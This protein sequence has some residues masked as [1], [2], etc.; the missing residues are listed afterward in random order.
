MPTTWIVLSVLAALWCGAAAAGVFGYVRF[1]RMGPTFRAK[2]RFPD[3]QRWDGGHGWPR[4]RGRAGWVHDVLLVRQGLTLP[5]TAALAPRA[6]DSPVRTS[7]RQELTR[8]GAHP[9]V[10]ALLLD[11]GRAVEVASRERDLQVLAGPFV[12]AAI[13][14]V[15]PRSKR[16]R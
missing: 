8:L 16:I 12:T 13:A 3:E 2:V 15:P 6:A 9:A 11:D 4:R 5:R 10:F 14:A 1:R 7:T